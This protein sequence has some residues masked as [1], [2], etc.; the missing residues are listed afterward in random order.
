MTKMNDVPVRHASVLA[1]YWHIG[2]MTMRLA[3]CR[4]P[5]RNGV[6]SFARHQPPLELQV[7]KRLKPRI[8]SKLRNLPI[9]KV[10]ERVA[11]RLSAPSHK[12]R[13]EP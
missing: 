1:E 13:E 2:A 9:W 3:S 8:S 12:S 5:T 6:K 7:D 11:D 10:C 4:V